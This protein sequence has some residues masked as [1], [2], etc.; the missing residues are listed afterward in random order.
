LLI[1]DINGLHWHCHTCIYCDSVVPT[2]PSTFFLTIFYQVPLYFPSLPTTFKLPFYLFFLILAFTYERKHVIFV[3]IS[4]FMLC[5]YCKVSKYIFYSLIGSSIADTPVKKD[6]ITREKHNIF[7][8]SQF[9]F[10]WATSN[11]YPKT[12]R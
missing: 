12:F 8:W 11:K 1:I 5:C 2:S 6:R 4:V 3:F 9:Y 10:S 7:I